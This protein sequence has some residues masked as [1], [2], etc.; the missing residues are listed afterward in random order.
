LSL[1][2]MDIAWGTLVSGVSSA[3]GKLALDRFD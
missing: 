3:A 1:S 2:L